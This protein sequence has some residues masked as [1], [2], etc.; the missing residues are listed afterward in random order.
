MP[1]ALY[2]LCGT[3]EYDPVRLTKEFMLPTSRQTMDRLLCFD[4][5]QNLN[6]NGESWLLPLLPTLGGPFPLLDRL[7][8]QLPF[9]S[10]T[11]LAAY[12]SATN[13]EIDVP[14]LI[15][16]AIGIFWKASVHSW[17][18]GSDEPRI[19]LGEDG[20]SLRLYLRGQADLPKNIALYVAVDSGPIR[21]PGILEPYQC[22][23]PDFKN[24]CF[25]IPGMFFQ[26]LIGA[27][28]QERLAANCINANPRSPIIVE[29]VSKVVRGIT[30]EQSVAAR[31]TKKLLETTAEIEE[32]G[33]SIKLGGESARTLDTLVRQRPCRP[34]WAGNKK[35]S[36]SPQ[37]HP[38]G[39]DRRRA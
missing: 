27:G 38:P 11:A 10:D 6:R 34:R 18:A 17:L 30:R 33:L 39:Y 23:N 7:M 4:C 14:K 1:R 22:S 25:F 2:P 29:E 26:L 35:Q 9:Y 19:D 15:H 32:R 20:E 21:L 5:E 8:K 36:H 37:T 12:A 28:V 3:D 31:K 16:F 13:P 24:F